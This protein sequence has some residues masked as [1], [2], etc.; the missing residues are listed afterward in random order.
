M[1]AVEITDVVLRDG[2]QDE[3]VVVAVPDRVRIADALVAAG[4]T[5]IEAASFVNPARVPQMAGAEELVAALPRPAGVRWSALALNRRG[6]HRAV[7]AGITDVCVVVSAGEGH[8]RANAGRTVADALADL[9]GLVDEHP[10]VRFTG[11]VSTAFVC[12]FDGEIAPARLAE[13]A[14]AYAGIGI[15]E[16]GLADTLGTADPQHVMRSVGA[17]RDAVPQAVLGLH[18]HDAL[19]QALRTVDLALD[20]GITRFDAATGGYGGCPFAPGAHGNLATEAL[21]EHLH[22]RGV[23]TGIDVG[24]LAEALAVVED[25][26]RRGDPVG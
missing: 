9:D 7:A 13:V 11:G 21:V 25:A 15:T 12:P 8:S 16:L 23:D 4:V 14:R 19:G 24:L 17:V 3:P 1:S 22:D 18:L 10:Q 26:L 5:R 2:L 6:V 20:L